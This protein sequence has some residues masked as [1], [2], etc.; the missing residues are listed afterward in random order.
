MRVC[1]WST[2]VQI[3]ERICRIWIVFGGAGA[4]AL[5]PGVRR[6]RRL[7]STSSGLALAAD[8][9]S[10]RRASTSFFGVLVFLGH[11]FV[12]ATASRSR[13]DGSAVDGRGDGLGRR[14]GGCGRGP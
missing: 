6:G 8:A 5:R 10:V 2:G 13:G 1:F 11:H 14:T 9:T 4:A 12:S 3:P 7:R